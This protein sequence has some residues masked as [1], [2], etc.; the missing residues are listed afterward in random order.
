MIA[1]NKKILSFYE[2]E[3]KH[4]QEFENQADPVCGIIVKEGTHSYNY[5]DVTYYFCT[6]E[7]KDK[8]IENP[9]NYT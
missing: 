1:E 3:T 4:N 8:F 2:S 6:E 9:D 7:C 5:H